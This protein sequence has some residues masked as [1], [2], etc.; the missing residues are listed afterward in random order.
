[1]TAAFID[2][3]GVVA[4][5]WKRDTRHVQAKAT[6]KRLLARRTALA[7]TDLVVAESVTLARTRGGFELSVRL[8][9]RLTGAQFEIVWCTA[10][11]LDAAWAL[12]R[13]YADLDLSLCDCVSFAVMRARGIRTAFAFDSDFQSVG[14]EQAK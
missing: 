3:S 9:E 1:M 7:T 14:F 10:S 4:L 11:L 5:M 13:K 12:Y 6:W 8:G 2:T